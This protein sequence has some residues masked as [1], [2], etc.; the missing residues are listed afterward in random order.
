MVSIRHQIRQ[1][2]L[3]REAE[4]YL[5]LGMPQHALA[6]LARLDDPTNLEGR[7][8]Y[9]WG[10]ALRELERYVEALMPL[11]RAAK[12]D[13]ENTQ[14][15]FALG[16]CYKRTGQIDRAIDSLEQVLIAEPAEPLVHYN[17]AC[18]WS[19]AGDTR[20]AIEF[21][22]QALDI[23]PKFR[24]LIDDEPDFDPMRSDPEFQAFQ[25]CSP[26]DP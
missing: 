19:L 4:G 8:F 12:A 2:K 15:W 20:R 14:V 9:L 22:A 7:T 25:K 5:E 16:W 17:L 21:L 10:E 3:Q 13:P 26:R 18:Y 1:A 11:A 24:D 6:A 23:D